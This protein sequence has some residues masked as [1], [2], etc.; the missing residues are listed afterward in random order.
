MCRLRA[1]T[2][3]RRRKRQRP[4]GPEGHLAFPQLV[5]RTDKNRN[6]SG[7]H[8]LRSDLRLGAVG[9][10]PSSRERGLQVSCHPA[11]RQR[12][13]HTEN[14]TL[15]GICPRSLRLMHGKLSI[16][17]GPRAGATIHARIPFDSSS[18]LLP[19]RREITC[20]GRLRRLVHLKLQRKHDQKI[21]YRQTAR[22]EERR[23]H[24]SVA[25]V[26]NPS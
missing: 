24:P 13:I 18:G 5:N 9:R 3:Y 17:S 6:R 10:I 19:E 12:T 15:Q 2:V 16:N 26:S 22:P 25:R 7:S 14:Q 4:D 20:L 8:C 1:P 21:S 11:P 23:P